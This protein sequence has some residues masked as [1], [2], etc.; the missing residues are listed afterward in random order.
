MTYDTLTYAGSERKFS[1]WG[2]GSNVRGRKV[3][4]ST[5]DFNAT[6]HGVSIAAEAAAPTFP[7]EAQVVVQVNR[8]SITGLP[9]SFSGGT[10]K[11]QGKRVGQP[12]RASAGGNGATYKF[13]GPWYD[14]ENTHY[15]QLFTGGTGAGNAKA[16]YLVAETVLNVSTAV[17]TGQVYISVGDQIQAVLQWLLDQYA[18][19]GLA[20]P[21]QYVGRALN[22]GVIDLNK[23]LNVYN[24]SLSAGNTISTSLYSVFLP[25]YITK[26]LMCADALTKQAE[27]FPRMCYWF[28]HS[29]VPP[30]FHATL[31]EDKRSVT[32]P[33]FD[34][35][36]H[37]SISIGRRDDLRV[38]AVVIVYRITDSADG[39]PV[40]GYA[41]DKWGPNGS[42]SALDPST[43][44]RVVC[45]LIDL[46]GTSETHSS[47]SLDCEPLAFAGTQDV[48]R[49][50]WASKRGGSVAKFEDLRCRF[51]DQN[52]IQ[53]QIM[54]VSNINEYGGIYYASSG[55]DSTGVAVSA[56]QEFTEADYNFY[57]YRLVR[58]THCPWM[59]TDGVAV[60]SVKVKVQTRATYCTYHTVGSS[61]T[62][63]SGVRGSVSVQEDIHTN[64][65]LTNGPTGAYS[66]I[67]SFTAGESYIIGVGGIAQYLFNHLNAYQ[68]DGDAVHVGAAFADA[69]SSLAV[70]PGCALN[71]SGGAAEWATMQ[72]QV[73]SI[74]EDY[75][76]H[77]TTVQIGV[78]KHLNAG[79]L[80]SILNMWRNRRPWYNPLLRTNQSL[81]NGGSV[82]MPVTAGNSDGVP[83]LVAGGGHTL[84]DYQTP[85]SDVGSAFYSVQG[86]FNSVVTNDPV[87]M[88]KVSL[89]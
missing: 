82:D 74:E 4:Q 38:R 25:S 51:Q 54:D 89:L 8:T 43:G 61:D 21:F 15:L 19:Q 34:S 10:V 33:L 53:T 62:D 52:G 73:Q 55:K 30:T 24:Y 66:S 28:D 18:A 59:V 80:S 58:G 86:A 40:V 67:T 78:A 49:A 14:L 48:K 6:I 87:R 84:I 44:L 22:T 37:E 71:L 83:G 20:A 12:A 3:N 27:L 42:N 50:W 11:F 16:T 76:H 35:K 57:I 70:D 36:T 65:E 46:Q 64:I 5:D 79:Q 68:Y 17:A 88:T 23:T 9:N 13:L 2:F 32:L 60:R 26:P 56:N 75:F 77:Q 63:K 29:T 47:G 45:E 7:F 31:P 69:G 81:S 1:D 39:T 85:P 41:V 72:A